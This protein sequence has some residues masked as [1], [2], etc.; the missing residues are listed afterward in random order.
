MDFE[1]KLAAAEKTKLRLEMRGTRDALG[2]EARAAKNAAIT[3][4]IMSLEEY[5]SA[6]AIMAYVAFGSEADPEPCMRAA[7]GEGKR[8]IIPDF[9]GLLELTGV[10][11]GRAEPSVVDLVLVPGIAFD[12]RG[13]RLGYGGGWY[14]R[15]APKLRAD[16]KMVGIAFEEQIAP[17]IPYEP[18]DLLLDVII[19][20][21]RVI[22]PAK[23]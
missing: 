6:E 17:E 22:K 11:V 4:R 10:Y 23:S 9:F 21:S 8:V 18:H 7:A 3:G 15:L 2:E 13:Y 1:E 5:L 19:T 12:E 14:D 20:D 16:V